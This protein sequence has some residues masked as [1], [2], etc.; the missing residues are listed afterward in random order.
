V[1][2]AQRHNRVRECDPSSKFGL[3]PIFNKEVHLRTVKSEFK[4]ER[5]CFFAKRR[6]KEP[7]SVWRESIFF[8]VR[9]CRK[10]SST[11]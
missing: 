4:S 10:S 7:I 3:Q 6:N 8:F 11:L 5:S 1:T 9:Y 2:T